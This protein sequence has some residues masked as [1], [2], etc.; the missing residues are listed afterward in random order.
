MC[1]LLISFVHFQST[2]LQPK[3]IDALGG[4]VDMWVDWEITILQ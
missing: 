1:I 4:N 3:W 2:I